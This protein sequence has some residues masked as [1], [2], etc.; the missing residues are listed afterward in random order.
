VTLSREGKL[1]KEGETRES[2]GS[3]GVK[4]QGEPPDYLGGGRMGD[5]RTKKRNR[6]NEEGERKQNGN[7]QKMSN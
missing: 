2:G 1:S 6:T 7:T 3:F 5:F 4:S